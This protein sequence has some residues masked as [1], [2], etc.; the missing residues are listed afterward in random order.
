MCICSRV[1]LNYKGAP[2]SS[3]NTHLVWAAGINQNIVKH[4]NLF[5][6]TFHFRLCSKHLPAKSPQRWVSVNCSAL[7]TARADVYLQE[8]GQHGPKTRH[9]LRR[10][11]VSRPVKCDGFKFGFWQAAFLLLSFGPSWSTFTHGFNWTLNYFF[12]NVEDLLLLDVLLTCP[13]CCN[14]LSVPSWETW[15]PY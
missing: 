12:N 7:A 6:N 14:N 15:W 10:H 13:S 3:P 9:G 5:C 2:W 1:P 11:D 4:Q 8:V